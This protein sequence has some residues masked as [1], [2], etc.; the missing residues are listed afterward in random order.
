MESANNTTKTW[1]W[2]ALGGAVF[3]GGKELKIR[4]EMERKQ[5][6]WDWKLNF[7]MAVEGSLHEFAIFYAPSKDLAFNT[8]RQLW[9]S[10]WQVLAVTIPYGSGSASVGR[11]LASPLAL[12]LVL[13]LAES[14]NSVCYS[15]SGESG[16]PLEIRAENCDILGVWFQAIVCSY[17]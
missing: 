3:D 4:E 2:N 17:V 9:M 7:D 10:R 11:R 16:I 12:G 15:S 6:K 14:T 5:Q 8:R 1:T 13:G